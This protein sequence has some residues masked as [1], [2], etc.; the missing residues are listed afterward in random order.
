MDETISVSSENIKHSQI[1]VQ[2]IETKL[3]QSEAKPF[4]SMFNL[5][6]KMRMPTKSD[7]EAMEDI[8]DEEEKMLVANLLK[9]DLPKVMQDDKLMYRKLFRLTQLSSEDCLK[10]K[11]QKL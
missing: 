6:E 4:V 1:Q 11:K 7:F 10:R 9:L 8:M 2:K 5:L 3:E